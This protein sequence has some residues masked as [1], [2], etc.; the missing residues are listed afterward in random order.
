MFPRRPILASVVIAAIAVVLLLPANAGAGEFQ[1]EHDDHP[2][3]F[4]RYALYPIGAV[5][6][7]TLFRPA[8]QIA[9]RWLPDDGCFASASGCDVA[10][11]R[12]QRYRAARR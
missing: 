10:R 11:K 1:R 5:L 8:H 3:V 6:E 2:L 4:L 9:A 12:R 7:Y